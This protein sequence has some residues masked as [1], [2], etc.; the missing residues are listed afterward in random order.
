MLRPSYA[1]GELLS[2]TCG[3][4]REGWDAERLDR[5]VT[6]WAAN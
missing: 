2:S 5:G 3:S 1:Q 6:S 4:G